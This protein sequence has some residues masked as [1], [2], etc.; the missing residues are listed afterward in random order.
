VNGTAKALFAHAQMLETRLKD[1][2]DGSS[3][4]LQ[5]IQLHN[6]AFLKT[7]DLNAA[8]NPISDDWQVR[9]YLMTIQESIF[10]MS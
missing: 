6:S 7:L 2:F 5:A 10:T 3:K 8:G 1:L 9:N 4:G